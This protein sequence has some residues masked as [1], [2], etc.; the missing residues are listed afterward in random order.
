VRLVK[1]GLDA[2]NVDVKGDADAVL[3]YCGADV[4][5]VWRNCRQAV[6]RGV[7]IELT[8]LV[9]PTVNDAPGVLCGIAGRIARELGPD[10]PWHVT[11]YCP[12]YRFVAPQT[13]VRTLEEAW[14][15]GVDAGL[16]Y[17]YVGNVPGHLRQHTRC[18][19]CGAIVVE[20]DSMRVRQVRLNKDRC[21]ACGAVIAGRF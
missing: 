6:G 14:Q 3:R 7:W 11:R 5:A 13:P 12:A 17:V 19:G 15:I 4:E 18:P 10:T 1:A 9:I 16:R 8:T 21:T 2:M 20:R